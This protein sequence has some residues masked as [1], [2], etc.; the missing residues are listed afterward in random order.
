MDAVS[1]KG[2]CAVAA[3]GIIEH[4]LKREK[5]IAPGFGEF[6]DDPAFLQ[7]KGMPGAVRFRPVKKKRFCRDHSFAG[8]EC[9]Q[10]RFVSGG[11][12]V[13]GLS[14]KKLKGNIVDPHEESCQIRSA[15][16]GILRQHLRCVPHRKAVLSPV[17]DRMAGTL[18]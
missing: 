4:F 18:L 12:I 6:S 1:G 11:K 2:L 9:L 7:K 8:S 13:Q 3:G 15:G 5:K 16:A 17:C 14:G 10:D